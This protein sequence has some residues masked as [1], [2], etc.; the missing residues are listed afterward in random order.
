MDTN[1]NVRLKN[2]LESE[3]K[4]IGPIYDFDKNYFEIC[5]GIKLDERIKV[6]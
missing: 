4:H 6:L 1:G 2:F 5:E 3:K